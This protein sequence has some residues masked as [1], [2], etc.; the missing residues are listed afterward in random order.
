M[1]HVLSILFQSIFPFYYLYAV[2]LLSTSQICFV[3]IR[4][5]FYKSNLLSTSLGTITI[6]NLYY[7]LQ[8]SW[9][10]YSEVSFKI[11]RY[12]HYQTFDKVK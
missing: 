8:C 10:A 12:F 7:Y 4:F 3:Q 11:P 5:A 9:H 1:I 2:P 6:M